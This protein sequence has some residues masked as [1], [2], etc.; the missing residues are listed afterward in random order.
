[1]Y[2]AYPYGA[3]MSILPRP[4][5]ER[6]QAILEFMQRYLAE[7]GF[8]PTLREI[9]ESQGLT[10]VSA[11]RGHLAALEKKGYIVKQPDKARSIRLVNPPSLLSR[12][13]KKLHQF[14]KTDEGVLHQVVYGIALATRDLKARFV[15]PIRTRVEAALDRR[16]A[17]HGWE[18]VRK[19]IESDR[20]FLAVRVWPN[21]SPEAVA[22][23]I[24]HACEGAVRRERKGL[25]PPRNLWARGYVVTTQPDQLDAL[26]EQF[27]EEMRPQTG[28]G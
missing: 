18:Y 14:A 4:T 15:G 5:T 7:H 1:M 16:A 27:I 23:R 26:A 6:Q 20:I 11:V 10:N 8:P 13:K 9:G 2:S 19:Q 21:H 3:F 12:F 24:R 25:L 22:S 17:E 28:P